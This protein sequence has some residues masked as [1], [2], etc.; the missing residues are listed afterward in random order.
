MARSAF[1]GEFEQITLLAVARL[2]EDAYGVA[3]RQEI[4]ERSGRP[5]AIGSVY[6]ALDR[7]ERK[8]LI[9]SAVGEPTPER[10]GRAKRFY[11]L[12]PVGRKALADARR[13]L[14]RFWEDLELDSALDP[15]FPA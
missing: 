13:T 10:G 5:V 9:R 7:M 2:G 1:L 8:G 3:I 11:D 12:S 6:A 4:E 14:D 15:E